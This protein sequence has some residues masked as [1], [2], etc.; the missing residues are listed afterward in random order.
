MASQPSR[1][2]GP[3]LVKREV[4]APA[5]PARQ[6]PPEQAARLWQCESLALSREKD[7]KAFLSPADERARKQNKLDIF[8]KFSY[9]LSPE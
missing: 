8:L 5:S 7:F 1:T 6:S 9:P 3:A 4:A 2:T